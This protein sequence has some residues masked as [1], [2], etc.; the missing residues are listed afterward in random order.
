MLQ[1]DFNNMQ[2]VDNTF[3]AVYAIEATCHADDKARVYGEIFRVLKPGGKFAFYEWI[4]TDAYDKNNKNHI[5]IKDEILVGV[6]LT[7]DLEKQYFSVN[8]IYQMGRYGTIIHN[9]C[10][11]SCSRIVNT[12]ILFLPFVRYTVRIHLKVNNVLWHRREM[13]CQT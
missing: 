8:N 10:D 3:D 7:W 5:K 4:V 13:A 6:L 1:G 9:F 12:R 11:I 2:F